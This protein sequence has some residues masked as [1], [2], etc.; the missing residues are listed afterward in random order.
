M[1]YLTMERIEQL[2]REYGLPLYLFNQE[3]FIQNY[4]ELEDSFQAIYPDFHICYSY[5]TN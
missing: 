4:R 3:E 5:K 1:M 2:E